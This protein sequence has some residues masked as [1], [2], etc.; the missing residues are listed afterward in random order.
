MAEDNS[1]EGLLIIR[2]YSIIPFS[3]IHTIDQSYLD[4]HNDLLILFLCGIQM[5]MSY[6]TL[7]VGS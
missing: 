2:R 7:R 3:R 4:T 6:E 5:L 1:N